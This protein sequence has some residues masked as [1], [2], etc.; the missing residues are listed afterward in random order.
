MSAWGKGALAGEGGFDVS[1]IRGG[2]SATS[3]STRTRIST[4]FPTG[5]PAASS[6]LSHATDYEARFTLAD[7][8]GVDGR[9]ENIVTVRTRFEPKP[10]AAGNTYH[11]YPPREVIGDREEFL[12]LRK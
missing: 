10:A 8:D 1:S 2:A 4:S 9:T 11:V 12:V 6:S 7:P 5:S 3:G